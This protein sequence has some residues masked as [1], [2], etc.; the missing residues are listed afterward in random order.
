[1][2]NKAVNTFIN[3]QGDIEIEPFEET[4]EEQTLSSD[5]IPQL[6]PGDETP[7]LEIKDEKN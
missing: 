1:M 7:Q 2:P 5:E 3:E 4:P 6:G